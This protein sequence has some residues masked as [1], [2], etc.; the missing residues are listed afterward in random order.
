MSTSHV[1]APSARSSGRTRSRGWPTRC[2]C[3]C[4]P[5]S[6]PAARPPRASSARRSASRAGRPATTCASCTGTASSR[7]TRSGDRPRAGVDPAS[8]WLEPPG[9]RPRRGPRERAGRRPGA[10]GP[11]RADQQRILEVMAHARPLAARSGARRPSAATP[12]SPST[13]SSGRGM[14]AELD[15]VDRPLPAMRA[16][17]GR[18]PGLGRLHAA[19]DRAR[20]R[21]DEHRDAVAPPG[22]EP[23]SGG[24]SPRAAPRT[25]P[26]ASCRPRCRC[27]RPR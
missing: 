4:S 20:G 26:T 6:T 16:R 5:S 22:S 25:S 1:R 15:E 23:R 27:S 13:P 3:A 19:P 8:W 14:H 17:R 24:C 7:R 18:P 21:V 2:G 11:A 9:P 10:P 12:T